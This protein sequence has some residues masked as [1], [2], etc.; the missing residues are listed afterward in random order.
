MRNLSATAIERRCNSPHAPVIAD[1]DH[2]FR[3]SRRFR[4]RQPDVRLLFAL[5]PSP[6]TQDGRPEVDTRFRYGLLWGHCARSSGLLRGATATHVSG[7]PEWPRV[8]FL[9]YCGP[10]RELDQAAQ[11]RSARGGSRPVFARKP[12]DFL[13][14]RRHSALNCSRSAG[15]NRCRHS[16]D[17]E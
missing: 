17:I 14:C 11:R 6:S 12:D 9:R 1:P 4:D 10:E 2:P 16:P 7:T 8:W 3:S 15:L 13:F 5:V